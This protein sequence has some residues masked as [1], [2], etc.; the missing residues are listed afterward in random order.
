MCSPTRRSRSTGDTP[1]VLNDSSHDGRIAFNCRM[2]TGKSLLY[3]DT[4]DIRN[5]LLHLFP[6]QCR[7]NCRIGGRF[8]VYSLSIPWRSI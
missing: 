3:V 1:S 6:A 5:G 7:D 4:V 8:S 2:V